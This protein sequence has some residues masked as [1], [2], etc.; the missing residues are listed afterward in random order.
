M[1]P[2]LHVS[3]TLEDE[4]IVRLT[5]DSAENENRLRLWLDH[6]DVQKRLTDALL[7]ALRRVTA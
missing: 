5:A 2:A 3:V 4:P 6:P 1:R 7:E